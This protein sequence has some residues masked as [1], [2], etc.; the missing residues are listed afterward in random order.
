[1]TVRK[2]YYENAYIREFDATV[3]SCREISDSR[4]AVT[5]D[6]TAFYPEGGGQPAD[7]GVIRVLDASPAP[8]G[9]A[10]NQASPGGHGANES[11]PAAAANDGYG[12]NPATPAAAANGGYGANESTPGG[13]GA[14]QATLAADANGGY[15]VNEAG[16]GGPAGGIA[17]LDVREGGDGEVVHFTR[18]PLPAG[19]AVRCALNWERRIELMRHHTGEHIVSGVI[20]RLYGYHNAGFHM[21][22][23]A[24]ANAGVNFVSVDAS[25]PLDGEQI[26]EVERLA[27]DAVRAG[28]P[29]ASACPAPSE[30]AGM[31]YRS[32]KEFS[33]GVRIVT[34]PGADACAC[35]GLHVRRTLEV[36]LVRITAWERYKGGTRL[37]MLCGRRAEED[38]GAK[39]AALREIAELLS[40]RPE[41]AAGA[42]RRLLDENAK[43]AYA[44]GRAKTEITRL[45][46]EN[47]RVE[48]TALACVFEEDGDFADI[49]LYAGIAA[50]KAE[51]AAV[52]LKNGEGKYRYAVAS[53]SKDASALAKELNRAFSG[54]GGGKS[55]LA[56][57][58]LTGSEEDIRRLA[59]AA[60]NEIC[61]ERS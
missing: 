48:D 30:L 18:E 42:V 49:A 23:G 22:M 61:G 2:L 34:I 15:A 9:S 57:G 39:N 54:K 16:P 59:Y 26:A 41:T 7:T 55:A 38:Y 36:G 12:A 11:T 50:E 20:N 27:N 33:G 1:M 25:G 47:L 53:K 6:R 45:R 52:F 19:A 17:V 56:Q 5:L 14:N 28:I 4:F 8:G 58:T 51:I 21:S 13:Y 37:Y 29:V 32:K 46:A 43:A 24:G 10:A 40:A 44:I 60:A 31:A 3:T 35:C